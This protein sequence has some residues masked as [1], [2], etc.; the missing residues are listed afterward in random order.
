[1]PVTLKDLFARRVRE[2]R[3]ALGLTQVEM[4]ERLSREL[5]TTIDG[6][7]YARL[8]R[9]E[10]GVRLDEAVCIAGVLDVSL[11]ALLSSVGDPTVRL[12]DLHEDLRKAQSKATEAEVRLM[13]SRGE[14]DRIQRAIE[15]LKAHPDKRRR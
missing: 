7:T 15:K 6:S 14:V 4:A 5:G 3:T 13:Q 8:E 1:M 9:G 2:E 10:R 11:D 12:M